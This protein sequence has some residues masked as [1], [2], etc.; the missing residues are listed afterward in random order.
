M[1]E[2]FGIAHEI[3]L[4]TFAVHL[5]QVDPPADPLQHGR[6]RC[7]HD[8]SCFTGNGL[9]EVRRTVFLHLRMSRLRRHALDEERRQPMLDVRLGIGGGWGGWFVGMNNRIGKTVA[10]EL[11]EDPTFVP[12]S[13]IVDGIGRI[14]RK[15]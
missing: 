8:A 3:P 15:P 5:E 11:G 6:K 12:M 7:K 4:G 1:R 10:R 14:V 9:R 2:Q 13:T